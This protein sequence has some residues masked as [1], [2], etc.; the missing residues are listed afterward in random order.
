VNR[1]NLRDL[2]IVFQ[3]YLDDRLSKSEKHDAKFDEQKDRE[4]TRHLLQERMD[5]CCS[6]RSHRMK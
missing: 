3:L 5:Q 6:S 4:K 2:V 1:N